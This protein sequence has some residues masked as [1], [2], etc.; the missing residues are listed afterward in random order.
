[1][2]IVVSVL[3]AMLG[4]V[5]IARSITGERAAAFARF[6]LAAAIAS[7]GTGAADLGIH[8]VASRH[9]ALVWAEA[10]K[11]GT[12]ADVS[13]AF[14]MWRTN[15]IVGN[16]MFALWVM[17]FFGVTFILFGL[18]VILGEDYPRWQGWWA[19]IGGVAALGI[20]Y[21]FT[22][23]FSALVENYLFPF[24]SYALIIWLFVIAV[25]LWRKADAAAMPAAAPGPKPARASTTSSRK[26]TRRK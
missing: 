20:G 1:V 16:S 9:L 15:E 26:S 12:P 21:S 24:A 22:L 23:E 17:A 2:G 14:G 5:A 3:L 6:G 10:V 19:L 4:M 7:T 8:G 25:Q 13:L 11:G 18:A